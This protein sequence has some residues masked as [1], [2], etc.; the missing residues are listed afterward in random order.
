MK[1]VLTTLTVCIAFS[2]NA[3]SFADSAQY[4]FAKG[5][6]EKNA[7]HFQVA[8]NNF[9]KA[10]KFNANYAEAIIE[11]GF[12]NLEMRRTDVAKAYFTKAHE[13]QPS[14]AV[15]IKELATL[16]YSYRQWDKAIEFVNKCSSCDNKDRIIGLCNYEKEN[17]LEADKY[18][19]KALVKEPADA[20]LNYKTAQNFIQMEQEKKAIPFFEKAISLEPTKTNWIYE[21]GILYYDNRNFRSAATAFETAEKNGY[22]VNNDFLENYGYALMYGGRFEAGELKLM[23]IYK[24]KGNKELLRSISQILYNY[25]Q[26]DRCLDY[27]QRLLEL[28]EKDGKALYQAGLTFIKLGKK[29]KGQG[30]CDKAIQLDPSLAGKKSAVGDMGGGL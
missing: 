2:A 10:I 4:Y 13:I 8:A 20:M 15:V 5:I 18:L 23:E 30:M 12:V 24:K 27:C 17:Y 7:K 6:E 29:D 26:Y 28:D 9:D 19:Q 25:Q 22:I 3:N 14:N 16:F 1:N 21:L 11:N